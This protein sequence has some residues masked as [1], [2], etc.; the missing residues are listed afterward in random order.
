MASLRRTSGRVVASAWTIGSSSRIW[1]GTRATRGRVDPGDDRLGEGHR[2]DGDTSVPADH[3]LVDEHV[4]ALVRLPGLRAGLALDELELDLDALGAELLDGREDRAGSLPAA[5]ARG[6]HEAQRSGVR[7]RLGRP[8]PGIDARVRQELA[9][10]D[11]LQQVGVEHVETVGRTGEPL[12]A[13]ALQRVL[14]GVAGRPHVVALERDEHRS[15]PKEPEVSLLEQSRVQPVG[16][17]SSGAA[18]VPR[19][20]RRPEVEMDHVE[21]SRLR[22]RAPAPKL[23]NRDRCPRRR[24]HAVDGIPVRRLVDRED[25][26]VE[27]KRPLGRSETGGMPAHGRGCVQHTDAHR[28]DGTDP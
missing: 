9:A 15:P 12:R 2:L 10:R 25:S 8:L 5:V 6:V 11:V 28:A 23:A 22:D 26:A 24:E 16:T 17:A 27:S 7:R 18:V 20:E 14:L 19:R 4:G 3:Q 13:A 1:A 21:A